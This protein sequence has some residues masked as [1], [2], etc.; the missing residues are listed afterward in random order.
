M[1]DD[2]ILKLAGNYGAEIDKEEG[3]R[4]RIIFDEDNIVP[5]AAA[6]TEPLEARIAEL[7]EALNTIW[8]TYL[9][10]STKDGGGV[11]AYIAKDA[12]EKKVLNEL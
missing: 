3:W 9:H 8:N 7:E 5:F 11:L 12:L 2:D 6:L 10:G 1:S 4:T